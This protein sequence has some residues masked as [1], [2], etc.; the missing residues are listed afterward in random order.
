MKN[1]C[2]DFWNK[3]NPAL[4]FCRIFGIAV[5]QEASGNVPYNRRP[6]CCA[7]NDRLDSRED[8]EKCT[9]PVFCQNILCLFHV[10]LVNPVNFLAAIRTMKSPTRTLSRNRTRMNM[11]VMDK[12]GFKKSFSHQRRI[13]KN[14]VKSRPFKIKNLFPESRGASAVE[15]TMKSSNSRRGRVPDAAPRAAHA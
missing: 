1:L 5:T 15:S 8:R 11:D 7:A 3:M 12:H 4:R 10:N 9:P 6:G 2:Y 14:F 13:Y